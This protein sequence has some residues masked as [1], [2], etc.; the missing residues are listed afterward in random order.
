MKSDVVYSIIFKKYKKNELIIASRL[1][2]EEFSLLL[3]ESSFYKIIERLKNKGILA[4][5]SK[6][7]YV[8]PKEG[9]FGIIPITEEDI[10]DDY[11]ENKKGMVIGYRLYNRLKLT[12]QIPF[13]FEIYSSKITEKCK[14]IKNVT[15]KYVDLEFTDEVKRLVEYLEVLENFT[16]I[17]DINYVQFIKFTEKFIKNYNDFVLEKVLKEL[18]YKKSTIA[19]LNSILDYYN[20]DNNIKKYLSAFSNYKIIK[21]GE[22]YEKASL[23]WI[24]L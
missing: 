19:F 6:G 23:E 9:E 7:I 17:E 13:Y 24:C 22:I 2:K 4:R 16:F 1:Y 8:M 21:M 14:T 10:I 3:S 15:I 18:K 12:T 20:I 11:I 5:V